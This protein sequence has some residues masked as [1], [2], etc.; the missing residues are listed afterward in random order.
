MLTDLLAIRVRA[1]APSVLA[2]PYGS[3][4]RMDPKSGSYGFL[5]GLPEALRVA[6]VPVVA[7]NATGSSR[8]HGAITPWSQARQY[9]P[10]VPVDS[11]SVHVD[12]ILASV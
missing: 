1:R 8:R 5:H 12:F 6:H 7:M 10:V 9:S 11:L 2:H 4:K 3:V